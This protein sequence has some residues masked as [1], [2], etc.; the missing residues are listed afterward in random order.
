MPV[1]VR[2][3]AEA[4]RLL[5]PASRRPWSW[6]ARILVGALGC[7]I[8]LLVWREF[9]PLLL[10]RPVDGVVVYAEVSRSTV[11]RRAGSTSMRTRFTPS[12]TY[13]YEVN[14][15]TFTSAQYAHTAMAGSYSRAMRQARRFVR[16]TRVQV[17]YSPYQPADA[18]LSRAPNVVLLAILGVLCF[19][20]WLFGMAALAT[21]GRRGGG[22]TAITPTMTR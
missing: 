3:F 15:E 19:M 5:S 21:S 2:S 4:P 1:P 22:A 12:I 8:A 10:F 20:V 9:E 6:P 17:W 13:S 18:V 11:R 14:G 16:G 7:L